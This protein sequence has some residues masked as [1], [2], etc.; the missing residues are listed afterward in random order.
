MQG[1]QDILVLSYLRQL[2]IAVPEI[3]TVRAVFLQ[4]RRMRH[5][6]HRRWAEGR[7]PDVLLISWPSRQVILSGS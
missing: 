7:L 1:E 4:A 6:D 2:H 5:E 3:G